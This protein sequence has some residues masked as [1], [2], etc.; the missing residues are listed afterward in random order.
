MCRVLP[1]V[2]AMFLCC[3]V[4]GQKRTALAVSANVD[5]AI[6]NL[7][8]NDAGIGFG[9]NGNFFA[10]KKL[11]LRLEASL[12]HFIGSKLLWVDSTGNQYTGNPTMI[13]FK[14][15]P[16]FFFTKQLSLAG[17]YGYV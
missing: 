17:L 15:G 5:F 11:Q 10:Q 8:T 6:K 7:I 1:L 14:G 2:L 12:D 9:L 16:E 3:S 13:S 4:Q